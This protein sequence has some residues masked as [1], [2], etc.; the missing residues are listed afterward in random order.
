MKLF[1][2]IPNFLL[3]IAVISACN[4][5]RSPEEEKPTMQNKMLVGTWRFISLVGRSSKGEVYYPYG[6]N[7]F[8]RLMYDAKGHMSVL[9]MRPDRPKFASGDMMKGTPDEIKAA[10]EGFDAYCGTYEV[11][12]EKGTV[13]HHVQ[14]SKFPNW[15]GTDQVRFF[16]VSGDQLRIT[17]PP[18]LAGDVR[19]EFEAVLTA[20]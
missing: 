6:E 14:G 8:G 13:T 5:S 7:L 19:W 10:F 20:L 11:D 9:L 17:A 2:R 12:A 15:V 3:L 16:E 18:I 4:G 1:Y